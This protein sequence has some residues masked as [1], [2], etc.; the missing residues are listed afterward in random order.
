MKSLDIIKEKNLSPFSYSIFPLKYCIT[1]KDIETT[2]LK[3]EIAM[4]LLKMK[5]IKERAT[6]TSVIMFKTV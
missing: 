5:S 1:A 2:P 6:M 3:R 4:L